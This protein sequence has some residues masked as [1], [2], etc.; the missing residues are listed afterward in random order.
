MRRQKRALLRILIV[1]TITV[2][3]A[4]LPLKENVNFYVYL[5][6]YIALYLAIGGDVV[7]NAFRSIIRG[8]VFDENFLMAI[9]TIGAFFVGDYLE[10][11]SV[12][13]FYQVGELFQS[14]AVGRSRNSITE[15]MNIKPDK[16]FVI[17]DLENQMIEEVE[18]E[19][20]LVGE[21]VLVKPGEKIPLDGCILQGSSA[22]DT[23]ALT[24]ESLPRD[25][26]AGD[27]VIS[28][29][30]NISGVL[31]V[32]VT[33]QFEESTVSRI[34]EMVENAGNKKAK[35]EKF[36]TRFAKYYTPSVVIIAVL[37][38]IIPPLVIRDALFSDWIY[39]ALSFL[40]VSCPCALVISIPLGFFGGIGGASRNGI[41]VKGSNYLEALAGVKT[42]VFDKTGTL[43]KG[44]FEV[45]DILPAIGTKEELLY[46]AAQAEADSNHPIARSVVKAYKTLDIVKKKVTEDSMTGSG[47][48]VSKTDQA[49]LAGYGIQLTL[50]GHSLCAG[51][52]KLM[53]KEGIV[54]PERTFSGTAVH[55]AYKGQYRGVI[56]VADTMK[57][58]AKEAIRQLQKHGVHET[59]MLTGDRKAAGEA[60]AKDL[61]LSKVY[62]ELLPGGK[63]EKL[64]EI[65]K[66]AQGKVL[67]VG[68]G[69]N[70][71]PVLARA[72]IGIAMGGFGSDAAIEAADIVI[73]TDEPSKVAQAIR[74]SRR[75]I[76][77]VKQNIVFA[78]GI[79]VGV[80]ILVALGFSNMWEAVFADV[81][82]AVLAILNSMRAL[83][84][85]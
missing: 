55:V 15:L 39:R 43:T 29:C 2:V 79:K 30:I 1:L 13:I 32:E 69:I 82:V 21:Q 16:A 50:N 68:D 80:L 47:N 42:A 73:M 63:V 25:V 33:K 75:T 67:Y 27:E 49:E 31:T 60:V 9:A 84:V 5:G 62:T 22:L 41:L 81:G 11:V 58:D 56:L 85:R 14:Y 10:A 59:V 6:L 53:L 44:V 4:L 17:R 71:A 61:N 24:G 34:L 19:A 26:M 23:S 20:V 12:M 35:T 48:A 52:D 83:K 28:G 46:L 66:S 54:V 51:N 77:I 38:A 7:R 18:P 45:T 40:V 8:S 74:I 36:I 57:P 76:Q 37:L 72:D 70:D 65:M 3:S 64:E 78:L